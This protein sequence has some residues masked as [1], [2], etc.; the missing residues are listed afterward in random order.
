MAETLYRGSHKYGYSEDY[1]EAL[2]QYI[3]WEMVRD[4]KAEDLCFQSGAY[5]FAGDTVQDCMD[6][7]VWNIGQL[8]RRPVEWEHAMDRGY[9]EAECPDEFWDERQ[10]LSDKAYNDTVAQFYIDVERRKEEL[11]TMTLDDSIS[12]TSAAYDILHVTGGL[13]NEGY[14]AT[15]D[16]EDV[17]I[18]S[19]TPYA[20]ILDEYIW[21]GMVADGRGEY[22]GWAVAHPGESIEDYQASVKEKAIGRLYRSDLG[23]PSEEAHAALDAQFMRDVEARKAYLATLDSPES[24]HGPAFDIVGAMTDEDRV[25]FHNNDLIERG[26]RLGEVTWKAHD[27]VEQK[28]S[29]YWQREHGG[30]VVEGAPRGLMHLE[31]YEMLD[32][33]ELMIADDNLLIQHYAFLMVSK[34]NIDEEYAI[35]YREAHLG[36]YRERYDAYASS[37]EGEMASRGIPPEELEI[38][39]SKYCIDLLRGGSLADVA[40]EYNPMDYT[41]RCRAS[42]VLLTATNAED[43]S[44][45]EADPELCQQIK[46]GAM[47]DIETARII[48]NGEDWTGL[49]T[50]AVHAQ[51]KMKNM[52]ENPMDFPKEECLLTAPELATLSDDALIEQFTLAKYCREENVQ[53]T[54]DHAAK[55]QALRAGKD[56]GTEVFGASGWYLEKMESQGD[57]DL[58]P[59]TYDAYYEA[60]YAEC[61]SRGFD[62]TELEA[63]SEFYISEAR[64]SSLSSLYGVGINI[65]LLATM[66]DTNEQALYYYMSLSPQ[67]REMTPRFKSVIETPV[68]GIFDGPRFDGASLSTQPLYENAFS[69]NHI[70]AYVDGQRV[71]RNDA[72]DGKY[73]GVKWQATECPCDHMMTMNAGTDYEVQTFRYQDGDGKYWMYCFSPYLGYFSYDPTEWAIGYKEIPDADPEASGDATKIPVLKYIGNAEAD[74]QH[75]DLSPAGMNGKYSAQDVHDAYWNNAALLGDQITGLIGWHPFDLD[76]GRTGMEQVH[77]PYGVKNL[78]YT[79]E[80]NDQLQLIPGIPSTVTSMHCTFK[81]C[82]ALWDGSWQFMDYENNSW[83]LPEGLVDASYTFAG[84]TALK[85]ESLGKFPTE[86]RTIEGMFNNCPLILEKPVWHDWTFDVQAWTTDTNEADWSESPYL[87]TEF[88]KPIDS[89]TSNTMKFNY[90]R[91]EKERIAFQAEFKKTLKDQPVEVQQAWEDANAAEAA[92]RTKKVLNGEMTVRPIDEMGYN[93]PEENKFMAFLQRAVIDVGSFALLKGVTKGITGS[94]VAGWV[95]GLGGTALLRFMNILPKSIEPALQWVKKLLPESAQEGMDKFISIIHIPGDKETAEAKREQ[96]SRYKDVALGDS[97]GRSAWSAGVFDDPGVMRD[98]LKINGNAIARYGV[99]QYCGEEGRESTGSVRTM[100]GESLSQAETVF[101]EKMDAGDDHYD[102]PETMRGYY[103]QMLYGLEGYSEGMQSG[104]D[105][106]YGASAPCASGQF[107][108][109]KNGEENQARMANAQNG[110]AYINCDYASAVMESLVK[111]DAKYH[112][113]R[114]EDW[115]R[116]GQ[117]H[118]YGVDTSSLYMYQPG[119]GLEPTFGYDMWSVGS[120]DYGYT[121]YTPMSTQVPASSEPTPEETKQVTTE[122]T[123]DTPEASTEPTAGKASKPES[124]ESKR[125]QRVKQA[126]AISDGIEGAEDEPVTYEVN[127]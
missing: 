78:D 14:V 106:T 81:D 59:D 89:N 71:D 84:C 121:D 45:Y 74:W 82:T 72:L 36:G 22:P 32:A 33:D 107:G 100:L 66:N 28:C 76:E 98:A 55:L 6:E 86:L 103:W 21:A 49:S 87:R 37:I 108:K 127:K 51:M 85:S 90:E 38:A 2:D 12:P 24:L 40:K 68:H 56:S 54:H 67:E 11:R 95:A 15:H 30:T 7:M 18:R 105:S 61:K 16:L 73:S 75:C 52:M 47:D 119:Q 25:A 63:D 17:E 35:D 64:K 41:I 122:K 27:T 23:A 120:D 26:C 5:A 118:I 70:E 91:E 46:V 94:K 34:G 19:S 20:T 113:M 1:N 80:G 114:D 116:I 3:W 31:D 9:G 29:S 58:N 77:I 83:E 42:E 99:A 44:F 104:I 112:F 4:G 96:M 43:V 50:H 53:Y 60:V 10:A 13:Q 69:L 92:V 97:I 101:S 115:L 93:A 8:A 48:M 79:F 124:T 39:A 117:L 110:A 102:W 126:E 65:H 111:M 123:V 109:S 62:M 125:T 57:I 88:S